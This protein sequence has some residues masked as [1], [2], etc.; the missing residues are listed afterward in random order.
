VSSIPVY[1][2]V[3]RKRV[4]AAAID[5]PGWCRG[6]RDEDGA[7]ETLA[8]YGSRYGRAVGGTGLGF[9]APKDPSAF[10]VVERL[11]GDATTDFGAPG[12]A[13]A[14][15]ERPLGDGELD[16]LRKL[17]TASW[18]TF[19]R[20][21]GAAGGAHLRKGPRGGGRELDAIVSHIFEADRA[22]LSRLGGSPAPKGGEAQHEMVRLRKAVISN[23]SARAHGEPLPPSRRTTPP[24]APRYAIR[25]SAWH[26]LDHA[27][28]IEDRAEPAAR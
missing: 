16:R 7:L 2:E 28:E 12:V 20:T 14:A 13:S 18:R 1:L 24:W 15:D 3:G 5:W 27:W 10:E 25:R 26:A 17:L 21:A 8:A 9:K 19:D 6:G 11:K 4:F 22:Y 23:L